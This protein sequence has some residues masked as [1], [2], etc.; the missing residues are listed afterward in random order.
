MLL[1][2]A[3]ILTVLVVLGDL[4]S[5]LAELMVT[6]ADEVGGAE[7]ARHDE[8]GVPLLVGQQHVDGEI[9]GL[10]VIL[11]PLVESLLEA[12]DRALALVVLAL[13]VMLVVL[14]ILLV[15]VE[16]DNLSLLLFVVATVVAAVMTTVVRLMLRLLVVP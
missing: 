10:A 15:L 16:P 4:R 11:D 9:D 3:V 5:A 12:S 8:L 7:G 2:V 1:V 14:T 6:E 13:V